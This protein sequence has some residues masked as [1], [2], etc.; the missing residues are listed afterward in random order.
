MKGG[1]VF[2]DDALSSDRSSR[3]PKKEEAMTSPQEEKSETRMMW[4]GTAAIVLLLL[5][6][7]GF[8]M[9]ITHGTNAGSPTETL[10]GT[11]STK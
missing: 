10:S 6:A 11:P 5:A 1:G 4:I 8:N 3:T 2:L 9:L 7:M